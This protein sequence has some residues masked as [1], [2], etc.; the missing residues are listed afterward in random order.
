MNM[1]KKNGGFTLVELIVVIAILAILAGVAVPAYSGYITK[2]QDAAV[3]TELDAIQTAAQAANATAGA[4]DKI[5][6]T[7]DTNK[8]VTAVV[9]TSTNELSEK[10]VDDFK[11]FFDKDASGTLAAK[12]KTVT[13]T[14]GAAKQ[15]DLAGTTYEKG[16]TWHAADDTATTPTFVAG[17]NATK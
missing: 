9:I 8:K 12:A 16:A 7:L 15:V 10:I 17:W 5:E 11:L 14:L 6:L 4:I 1:F 2:A 3:I 13:I